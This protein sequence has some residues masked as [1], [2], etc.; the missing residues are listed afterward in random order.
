[1]RLAL[2][3]RTKI[4][5]EEKEVLKC[6][7]SKKAADS[8]ILIDVFQTRFSPLGKW[9]SSIKSSKKKEK[10]EEEKGLSSL[11]DQV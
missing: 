1:M 11:Q 10:E 6:Q 7:D 9:K 8:E 5:M 4:L 2:R 3:R